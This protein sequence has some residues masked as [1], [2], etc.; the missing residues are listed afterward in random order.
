MQR[1]RSLS[2]WPKISRPDIRHLDNTVAA[3]RD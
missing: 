1:A 3:G 2:T